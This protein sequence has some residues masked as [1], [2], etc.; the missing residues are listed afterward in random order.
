MGDHVALR[1]SN[2]FEDWEPVDESVIC[3]NTSAILLR[4]WGVPGLPSRKELHYLVKSAQ[5]WFCPFFCKIWNSDKFCYYNLCLSMENISFN[6]F[7]TFRKFVDS[8]EIYFS[9]LAALVLN[10]WPLWIGLK[11]YAQTTIRCD[12]RYGAHDTI[13][14][15]I[16]LPFL[17]GR[18]RLVIP[19]CD[20]K[21]R[22]PPIT[23]ACAVMM[24]NRYN[25]GGLLSFQMQCVCDEFTC[26][27]GIYRLL[28]AAVLFTL[29]IERNKLHIWGLDYT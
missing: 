7:A 11:R 5:G 8:V 12:T 3:I 29:H 28:S 27:I 6:S 17:A 25:N 23:T 26:V 13:C 18:Q 21:H 4:P 2:S 22:T 15:A 1:P 24:R 20:Q 9:W 10:H 14:S 19:A 16:H